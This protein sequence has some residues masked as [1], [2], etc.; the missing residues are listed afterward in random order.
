MMA[1]QPVA[2][3]ESM[4]DDRSR[5]IGG[6][7]PPEIAWP[8]DVLRSSMRYDE[9]TILIPSHSLEDFPTDLG[10]KPA[11]SLLNAFAITWHPVL[12]AEARVLPQWHRADEPPETKTNRLFVVPLASDEWIPSGWIAHAR[13]EG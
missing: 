9:L 6:A 10:E 3:R 7:A 1:T 2:P 12:L 11:S 13:S 4:L 5:R 8:I